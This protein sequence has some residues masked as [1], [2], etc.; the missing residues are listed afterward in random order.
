MAKKFSWLIE[1]RIRYHRFWD[2]MAIEELAEGVQVF[3]DLNKAYAPQPIHIL[4]DMRNVTS[5]ALS[6][7]KM[8]DWTRQISEVKTGYMLA[9]GESKY[10][11]STILSFAN[12]LVTEVFQVPYKYIQDYAACVKFLTEI[13]NFSTEELAKIQHIFDAAQS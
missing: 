4:V 6:M 10:P 12:Q 3:I 8:Y 2:E 11:L 5:H 1:G 13:D 9:V 7:V